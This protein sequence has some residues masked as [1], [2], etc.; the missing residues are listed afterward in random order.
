M[1]NMLKE[2]LKNHDFTEDAFILAKAAT[3]VRNDILNH[4]GFIQL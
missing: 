3:I 1:K 2:A 4:E